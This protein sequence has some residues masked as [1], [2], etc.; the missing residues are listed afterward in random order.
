M[1]PG[2]LRLPCVS[3]RSC[4]PIWFQFGPS[5]LLRPADGRRSGPP[6]RPPEVVPLQLRRGR[7]RAVSRPGELW[8]AVAQP[9]SRAFQRGSRPCLP[10][11][12]PRNA[13]G[14]TAPPEENGLLLL[15][16]LVGVHPLLPGPQGRSLESWGGA[17]S[18]TTARRPSSAFFLP[19]YFLIHMLNSEEQTFQFLIFS[20]STRPHHP[21]TATTPIF[22][23]TLLFNPTHTPVL[24]IFIYS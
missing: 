22:L 15:C 21:A 14:P 1:G 11:A 12:S 2:D 9:L 13:V 6:C 4:F 20:P 10:K 16:D 19:L 3:T 8:D 17:A 7:S 24:K 5:S 18:G 23:L